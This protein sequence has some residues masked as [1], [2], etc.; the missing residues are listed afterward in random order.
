MV[1][2][3]WGFFFWG[4]D[5]DADDDDGDGGLNDLF[6]F[7]GKKRCKNI[8]KNGIALESSFKPG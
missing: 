1:N 4:D 6:G 2:G 7:L 8:V 3:D 5:D